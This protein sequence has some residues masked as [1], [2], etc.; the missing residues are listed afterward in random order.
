[1]TEES[2]FD[3]R[4]KFPIF[5]CT[6]RS[7]FERTSPEKVAALS[8]IYVPDLCDIIGRMY[9]VKGIS[10]IFDPA[11]KV[12]GSAFTVKCPPGDNLGLKI[13]LTM[14]QPGDVLIV[15]AQG[16]DDWCLGGF[17]MLTLTI[18]ERGLKGLIV[19]GA[20]RDRSEAREAG[21][22]IYAKEVS[23]WS[24][25]K[26]GPFEINVPV[27]CGGVIVEPGDLVSASED[28][29]AV[30]PARFVDHVIAHIS[31]KSSRSPEPVETRLRAQ[32]A[33]TLRYLS[34]I[35]KA[36]MVSSV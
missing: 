21:F 19:N 3:R 30:V 27:C 15:D 23:S 18:R 34:A 36:G 28:G 26:I 13:A 17:Q 35:E 8:S 1:M 10:S 24:G 16:F 6:I 5:P 7:S 31:A 14:T 22:P 11:V 33:A 20:Y 12:T 32:D 4:W 25:P 2:P 9:T 29:I